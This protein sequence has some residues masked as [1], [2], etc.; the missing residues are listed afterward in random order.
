MSAEVFNLNAKITADVSGFQKG[1]QDAQRSMNTLSNELGSTL[2]YT[3]SAINALRPYTEFEKK[4]LDQKI[5]SVQKSN[6]LNLQ[7]LA[8]SKA[9]IDEIYEVE[10]EGIV[11][12]TN[13]KLEQL[14]AEHY[15]AV[16]KAKINNESE[17][18]INRIHE[19]YNNERVK[20]VN[21]ANRQIEES[22]N[23]SSNK[24]KDGLK[25]WGV[26]LDQF[27]SQGSST[28]NKFGINVDKF[29]SHFGMSG[30]MMSG[31]VACTTALVKLGQEMDEARK[32]IAL[33]TGA[34]GDA[35]DDL[36]R[37][38]KKALVLG[39][40]ANVE[41]TGK[42]VADLNTRFGITGDT[43]EQTTV[44][45]GKFAKVAGIDVSNAVNK[46]ADVMARWNIPLEQSDELM[47]QLTSA[48]QMS[49][50]SVDELI[51][52]VTTGQTYFKQFGYSLSDSVA[53]LSNF[54]KNGIQ[55]SSV[56]M[57]MRTALAKFSKEG[58]DAKQGMEEVSKAIQ[59]ASSETEAMAL[60]VET[61]G[62]RSGP[63]MFQAIKNGCLDIEEFKNAMVDANSA[64]EDTYDASRTSKD[65]MNDLMNSLKGTFG[66][67]GQAFSALWKGLLDTVTEFVRFFEPLITPIAEVVK[68][69]FQ[70][71]ADLITWIVREVRKGVQENESC[72]KW[73]VKTINDAGKL[74]KGV[75]DDLFSVIK[76]TFGLIISIINGDW[77]KAWIHAQL[78][79]LKF[80]RICSK[81]CDAVANVFVDMI[82]G[83]G[84]KIMEFFPMMI[85]KI[86]SLYES[87]GGK[88]GLMG[89]ANEWSGGAFEW[90]LQQKKELEG[91]GYTG[92]R[93]IE[94][95]TG[96]IKKATENLWKPLDH[97]SL[98]DVKIGGTGMTTNEYIADLEKQLDDLEKKSGKVD[99]GGDP[100]ATMGTY[101][102]G[103]SETGEG[104]DEKK[105]KESQVWIQKRLQQQLD[106][107][108]QE[109]E[110]RLNAL[111]E[112]GATQEQLDAINA[113][114][115][116]RQIAK[117]NELQAIKKANDEESIKDVANIEEE[118]L[119]LE[120]W[121][122]DEAEK[123]RVEVSTNTVK[124]IEKVETQ[125]TEWK[126]KLLEQEID[127]LEEERALTVE[128]MKAEGKTAQE[129][130]EAQLEYLNQQIDKTYEL[131]ELKKKASLESA[132]NAEE[133]AEIEQ[134]YSNETASETSKV[135]NKLIA[136]AD[137]KA[138]A[139]GNKFVQ[140]MAKIGSTI[141][142]VVDTT[143]KVIKKGFDM[144]WKII[145][146]NP[147]EFLD[148]LLKIADT[149][150]TFFIETVPRLPGIV[151]S[152]GNCIE[153]IADTITKPEVIDT[154]MQAIEDVVIKAVDWMTKNVKRILGSLGKLVGAIIGALGKVISEIDWFQL[155]GEVLGGLWDAIAS[156]GQ[157]LWD[158]IVSVFSK[159]GEWISNWW[160]NLWKTVGNWWNNMW[161]G[162][163]NW[164]KGIFGF[165]TGT[166]NA[167]SGLA[168]VGER[169]P[170]LIDLHGGERIYNTDSTRDILSG[171][172]SGSS[173]V[174]NVTFNNTVDTTAYTMMRQL[175]GYQRQMAVN[176]II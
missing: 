163:G 108:T 67:F 113:V 171:G 169:G 43:L 34:I 71:I 1:V 154:L 122:A 25:N 148:S 90:F 128:T 12:L 62:T 35:L 82:N 15:N 174:W 69:V 96:Q 97:V 88:S 3:E 89:L 139:S 94:E 109:K 14:E 46:M 102:L 85:Q 107:I 150:E 153:V 68:F 72:W 42:L 4:L 111:R 146:F 80:S 79:V 143:V 156:I 162:V 2:K 31:I 157:G 30:K 26:N 106:A 118:K 176:G 173:N 60:A 49:G 16:E 9:T 125:S 144:A 175:K 133:Q 91:L 29:A 52:S 64:L 28:F 170:E 55:T 165:A 20:I 18:E 166:N 87:L 81:I 5:E 167:P 168:L 99:L 86:T 47:N 41:Q 105:A 126:M 152:V 59:N 74:I 95:W 149:I 50:A 130:N 147:D 45:F 36:E 92:D 70:K 142:K 38:S 119:N 37:S 101:S 57:G 63:E 65:A 164:F 134:Y 22:T 54:R 66:G 135:W 75:L 123:Y 129:I 84:N 124:A 140:V 39:V 78:I 56:L 110:A 44:Q 48:S 161:K 141:K 24:I 17:A 27:Y 7:N 172:S 151:D 103:A 8:N 131:M 136:K 21:E 73:I 40:G 51:S 138:K 155:L 120:Q 76:D 13:L 116:E 23:K 112:E 33:G 137:E 159:I 53:L 93:L 104:D 32:Q 6:E 10:K 145:Q 115:A 100:T 19:Y 98:A 58:K 127:A 83:V 160:N 121:Y 61:F 77:E 114:F 11:K 132:K 117:Y 158:G